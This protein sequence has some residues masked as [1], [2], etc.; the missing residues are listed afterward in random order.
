MVLGILAGLTAGLA[1]AA[2]DGAQRTGSAL[3]R[4]RSHTNASDAAVF[5]SQVGVTHP[6]W[7]TLATRP[8]VG[9]IARWGLIFGSIDGQ[10]NGSMFVPMDRTWLGDVDKPIVV[11]G[12]MFD[13][14]A[15]DEVVITDDPPQGDGPAPRLGDVVHLVAMR[16][17]DFVPP[18]A[19]PA[20]DLKVVGVVHTPLSLVFPGGAFVSPGFVDRY[21]SETSIY[22]NGLVQLRHGSSDVAALRRDVTG[23]V[24]PGAPVLD[25][26]V[27]GR[28]VTATTDVEQAILAVV[29]A[30]VA[31]GGLVFVGQTVARSAATIG[32]DAPTLRALGMTRDQ[33]TSGGLRP[34]L[35]TAAIA[36]VTTAITATVA[37]RWFPVGLA[38]HV[39]PDR[40]IQ[41]DVA[42]VSACSILVG[43][44]VIMGAAAASHRAGR[45]VASR[46][47][48]RISAM[49]RLGFRRPLTAS[50]GARMALEGG[51]R[52]RTASRP[53]LVGAAAAVAGVVAIVTLNHG[54]NDSLTHPEVAGVAWDAV[55]APNPDDVSLT[56]GV[57]S[58]VVDSVANRP[59]VEAAG[60]IGRTV[61]DIGE[62]GVPTFTV[63]DRTAGKNLRLVTLSGRAPQ[64]ADEIELGPSTAHDLHVGVGDTVQLADAKAA[65]VVGLGLFPSDVHAQFD[66]GGWV[67]PERWF[68]LVGDP[69]S[70]GQQLD[71]TLAVRFADRRALAAQTADLASALGS[72][73]QSVSPVSEPQELANLANVRR[74]PTLLAALL[75]ILG[76]VA[77]GHALFSSVR[78]RRREFAVLRALGVTRGGARAILASHGT[79]VGVVGL[80]VGL[81]IGLVA[82]RAGWAAVAHRVP[83]TFRSPLTIAVVSVVPLALVVANALALLP[84]RRAASVR[85]ALVLRSE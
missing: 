27:T 33:L 28:R 14:A 69:T 72:T 22:E 43:L 1:L 80:L 63:I 36:V 57:T 21:R 39:D 24:A 5:T 61:T 64:S 47:S 58:A 46:R 7:T 83:L 23:D 76:A 49:A 84:G 71:L 73:V 35:V 60:T 30:I 40:G 17:D 41:A 25:F 16:P 85:P 10:Q 82:G 51:G 78:R 18:A 12:R 32:G 70:T 13:P 55:V 19:G 34:H 79:A 54:L 62:V 75:S 67:V 6:D 11:A 65:R 56:G 74:L 38:A 4:L 45:D 9:R 44:L 66:E 26:K 48:P 77:V 29:A 8:G 50:I 42:L 81:P 20:V 59:G 3:A 68:S 2:F 15:S 37:S 53:A 52:T 31:V